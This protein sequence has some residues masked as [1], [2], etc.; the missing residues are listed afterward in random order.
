[1]SDFTTQTAS[2][3][4]RRAEPQQARHVATERTFIPLNG[5]GHLVRGDADADADA[6]DVGSRFG[7]AAK[8]V[9]TEDGEV[10]PVAGPAEILCAR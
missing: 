7:V 1:M 6:V 10:I 4:L 2:D 9:V 3:P 8:F 5:A